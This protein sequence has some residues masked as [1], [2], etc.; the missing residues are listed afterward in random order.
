MDEVRLDLGLIKASEIN[1]MM[2]A[3]NAARNAIRPL[4]VLTGDLNPTIEEEAEP[5]PTDPTPATEQGPTPTTGQDSTPTTTLTPGDPPMLTGT[6]P[7]TGLGGMLPT[8]D[9]ELTD[10][11]ETDTE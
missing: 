10:P 6:D 9:S 3:R 8:S 4:P 1:E 7:T 5:A 11:S 2:A